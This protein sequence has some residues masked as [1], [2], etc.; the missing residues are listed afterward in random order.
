MESGGISD[1][2]IDA[3]STWSANH[4]A[5]QGRLH[6]Q[7]TGIKAGAWSAATNDADQWLQV[8]MI[9]PYTRVTGVATQG[10]NAHLPGEWVTKYRLRYSDDGVNYQYYKQLKQGKTA[11]KIIDGNTDQDS[12]VYHEIN[13]PIS[14]RLIR[15]RPVAWH[16]HISMRVE[17]YGCRVLFQCPPTWSAYEGSCYK[18]FTD[19]KDWN[20]AKAFCNTEG[21]QL[22]KI[23]NANE[24]D[25][26]KRE[27]LIGKADY[28]IGLTDAETENDWEW[29]EGCKLTGY[30]NWRAGQPSN[31]N[32]QDCVAIRKGNFNGFN[33]DGEWYD[34]KCLR[35]KRFI[36]EK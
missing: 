3:S 19:E 13:P 34:N 27:F 23:E 14:A 9:G 8:H 6:F 12:V 18:L 21:A 30:T 16:N 4:A 28:W 36:C 5:Q 26:I 25:F 17:L 1:A 29:T 31:K 10:K 7:A 22:V 2:Q 35:A 33:S 20:S 24:N 11:D 32:E 15:F